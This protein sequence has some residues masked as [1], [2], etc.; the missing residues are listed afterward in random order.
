MLRVY[1]APA[2]A[3]IRAALLILLASVLSAPQ[4]MAEPRLEALEIVTSTGTRSLQVELART[5]KERARGL[6]NRRIL[7]DGRGMLFDF[8]VEDTV[9]MWMKNTYIPLDMIF[10]S[11]NGYVVSIARDTTPMSE[12]VISSGKPAYA[13][14]EVN[15]G[16][17][18]KLG[19][20]VGDAVLHPIFQK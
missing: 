7:P 6:M 8:K 18:D 2:V 4:C 19:I 14:I 5:T 16:V 1:R 15:A 13:V 3:M 17:S 10:V 20:G 11:R 9:F 12:A